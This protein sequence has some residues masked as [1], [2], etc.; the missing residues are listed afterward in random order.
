MILL[1]P[2][3]T[4]Y[5]FNFQLLGFPVRIHPLFWLMCLLTGFGLLRD[6]PNGF[7]IFTW[8]LVVFV[9]IL[10]HELGHAIMFRRFG[11]PAH[12]VLYVMGGLAIAGEDSPQSSWSSYSSSSFRQRS[13]TPAERIIIAFAGPA[14]GFILAAFVIVGVYAT[15]GYVR[16]ILTQYYF[17]WWKMELGG[18]MESNANLWMLADF[19][20]QVN[21]MWGLM[22]LLP[23][24]PLDGGQIA[25]QL[26]IVND[27]WGGTV[28]ALWLSIIVAGIAAVLGLYPFRSLFVALMFASLAASNYFTLQQMGGG[29]GRRPW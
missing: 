2:Q 26:M 20:L 17:P 16:P 4:A 13:H 24:F 21:I 9:S 6:D 11:E 7:A 12:I 19:L 5:D 8:C 27:P 10:I 29:G 14:A 28:R 3:R 1:E 22:N 18:E 25:Q 15:G 23:V